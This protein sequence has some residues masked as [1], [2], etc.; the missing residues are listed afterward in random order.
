MLNRR[1]ATS[2]VCSTLM[3][4]SSIAIAQDWPSSPVR[5][6]VP[7]DAGSTPDLVARLVS[8]ELAKRLGQ[9][10]VVDNRSGGAGNIGTDAV[11]KAAADGQTIG[12]SIAGPLAVNPLLFKKM[13][14]NPSTDLEMITV[15]VSQ[16][17]VLVVAA[18]HAVRS[19]AELLRLVQAAKGKLSFASIGAGSTSHL[20]MQALSSSTQADM[21]HVPYRGSGAAVAALLSGEVDMALLPAAAVMPHVKAAR[22]QAVAIA[23]AKRSSSLPDLPTFTEGGLPEIQADAW[24]GFIAPAKTPG[25]I[26]ERLHKEIVLILSMPA[27]EERLRQVYMDPVGNT[28]AAF[29]AL[30]AADVERWKPVIQKHNITRD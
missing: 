5:V 21:V 28:P 22:L 7:F 26:I 10:M 8:G 19:P 14:Y 18:K 1:L 30:M 13:P 20:A 12:V 23:S 17:A 9:P 4:G 11:A 24:I 16:P 27:I 6:V 3:L 15:A 25:A 29:R 2:I